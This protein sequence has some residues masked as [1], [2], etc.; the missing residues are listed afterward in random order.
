MC[1]SPARAGERHIPS[2]GANGIVPELVNFF[3]MYYNNINKAVPLMI[4]DPDS[5]LPA[6]GG[7]E[8]RSC[9][10]AGTAADR[11]I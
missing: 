3:K 10:L 1:L 11:K 4:A 5:F 6:S 2:C 8:N 9:I 7:N